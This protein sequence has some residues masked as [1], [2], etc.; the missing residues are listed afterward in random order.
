MTILVIERMLPSYSVVLGKELTKVHWV[1]SR[2]H[3]YEGLSYLCKTPFVVIDMRNLRSVS[4]DIED[5]T[6]CVQSGFP[7]GICPSVVVGGD[8]SGDAK[9]WILDREAMG[10]D[11]F[12]A[13]R[14]GGGTSFGVIVSWKI[15]L[16]WVPEKVTIFN[17]RAWM[18]KT[19][20]KSYIFGNM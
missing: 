10:E 17:V 2:G 20:P 18:I 4:I 13:I 9:G 16:L 3:D 7:V 8:F 19:P 12:W 1:P 14:G 11:L 5:A 15:K 6:A